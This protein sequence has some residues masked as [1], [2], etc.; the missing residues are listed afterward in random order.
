M[1]PSEEK[2]VKARKRILVVDDEIR[3]AYLLRQSLLTV[4]PDY[5]IETA[6]TAQDAL[7]S[8]DRKAFDLVVTDCRMDG[9]GGLELLRAIRAQR[10]ETLVIL[11]TAFGS[12]EIAAE[13]ERWEAYRY[14]TKPFPIEDFQSIVREALRSRKD[15][16]RYA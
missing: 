10:P 11:M 16:A 1:K 15:I 7:V 8:L 6:H 2:A 9:M 4:D 5:E 12:E 13:A 14:I 3:L